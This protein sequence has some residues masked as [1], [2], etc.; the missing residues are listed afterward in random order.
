MGTTTKNPRTPGDVASTLHSPLLDTE[1]VAEVL[2]VTPRHIRR[3]VTERR[4][5]F[6]KVGRFI[7]FDAAALNVWLDE[8]RVEP[9]R[10]APRDYAPWR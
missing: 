9:V 5:P 3:L 1:A 7:R 10:P 8:Q 6:L 2:G 4:I